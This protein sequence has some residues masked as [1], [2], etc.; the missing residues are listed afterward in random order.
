VALHTAAK[1]LSEVPEAIYVHCTAHSLDLVV[2]EWLRTL[3]GILCTLET[4]KEVYN[5]LEGSAKRH[6][7]FEVCR[8]ATNNTQSSLR[9]LC[10]TR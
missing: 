4:V 8:N 9:P 3:P 5:H 10:P 2:Q 1:F 6:A 7:I